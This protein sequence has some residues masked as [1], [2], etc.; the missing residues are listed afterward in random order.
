M[1]E[2]NEQ[3]RLVTLY[4][5]LTAVKSLALT[6]LNIIFYIGYTLVL[7][8]AVKTAHFYLLYP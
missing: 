3:L 4:Y 5:R 7:Y 2:R 1:I 8:K 6:A